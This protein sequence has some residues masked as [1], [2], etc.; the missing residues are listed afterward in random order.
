MENFEKIISDSLGSIFKDIASA[1][2]GIIGAIIVLIFGW[3]C[4]K[5]IK[6]VLKKILKI[7][8]INKLSRKINDARL[9]G[10]DSTIEVDVSKIILGFVKGI[11]LLVFIIVAADVMGLKIISTEIANLLRYLPILLSAVVIFMIG[12]FGAKLIK[13]AISNVFESMGVGGSKIISNVVYYIVLIF[14]LITSLN[15]AGIDTTIITSNFTIILGAFLLAMAIALGLGSR[16][17]VGDLLRTFYS[18]RIYEVGDK[19]K[20]KNIEGTVES[21]DNIAMVLKTKKGK[22]VVPIRKVVENTVEVE[23]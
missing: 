5:V 12:M 3:V 11:L 8:N 19:V 10:D 15:Q 23:A 22:V 16:E 18:R 6:L 21:I 4:I 1:L 20:L 7:A 2:P 9:F 17:V 13:T 14:V